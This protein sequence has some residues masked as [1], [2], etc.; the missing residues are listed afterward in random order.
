MKTNM[1][2]KVC[3]R[4]EAIDDQD[5]K[6]YIVSTKAIDDI[7]SFE[8]GRVL[9]VGLKGVGKT[10][11]FRYF[12]EFETKA[13][14]IISISQENYTLHLPYKNL[15]H[16]T[17]RKQFEHDLVIEA[18][19][20]LIKKHNV[21]K[22][23]NEKIILKEAKKHVDAYIN[24]LK[25]LAGRFGGI[26]ILGCGFTLTEGRTPVLV[27]L[28]KD[29]DIKD[30]LNLLKKICDY[31]IKFRI[32]V[33]DPDYVFSAGRKLDTHL[34][35]GFC[36]AALRLSKLIPNLKIIVLLRTSVYYQ[37][38]YD[39][40]DLRKYIDHMGRLSWSQKELIDVITKRLKWAGSR[41]K[42]V[43]SGND[44]QAK[45][46]V[47]DNMCTNLRNGPRD[48]LRWIFYSLQ[49][50]SKKGSKIGEKIIKKTKKKM[51][52]NSL[53]ELESLY[54]GKY[55]KISAVIKAIFRDDPNKK[56]ELKEMKKHIANLLIKEDEMKRLSR[57]PWMQR[58]TS[59]T[60]PELLFKIGV[61]AIESEGHIILPYE[62][63]YNME[64]FETANFIK[65]VPALTE[66]IK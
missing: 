41:W 57:L 19:S 30:A 6:D 13:D 61:F 23:E 46:L 39:I 1:F 17:C 51:S 22:V 35:G 20:A 5:L 11:A 16:V 38:L 25:K 56:Y 53:G 26:S 66:A 31:G 12:T 60:L 40:A 10:T 50:T 33:D 21:L 14:V 43:F 52:V 32:V 34:I 55:E 27:G 58:E 47:M 64:N 3:G 9:A 48:L 7:I 28:R 18:L 59:Q 62:E 49:A 2:Q 54:S 63:T 4:L 65:L 42:N 37:V 24:K 29:K 15:N 36:L 44:K 45:R 8:S